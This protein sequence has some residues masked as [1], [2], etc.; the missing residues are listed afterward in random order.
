MGFRKKDLRIRKCLL[1]SAV[2]KLLRHIQNVDDDQLFAAF[3]MFLMPN[4]NNNTVNMRI[5]ALSA[6]NVNWLKL[7]TEKL[8]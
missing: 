1:D 2:N 4:L 6:S 3:L 8:R 7:M 5:F